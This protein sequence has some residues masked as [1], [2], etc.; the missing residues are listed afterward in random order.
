[1]AAAG[2][3]LKPCI[4]EL[5]GKSASIVFESA[6][7]EQAIDGALMG[8]YSNNG[9]QCLAGSRI[10]VQ[11]TIADA[12]IGRF[13]ERAQAMKIGDPMAAETGDRA[14]RLQGPHGPR[15]QFLSIWPRRTAP[16]C[17]CGGK[18]AEGFEKGYYIEP[19]AVLA[20]SN[21]ARVCQ[22][23]IFGP[24]ATF[25]LFDSLDEAIAIANASSF[26]LVAYVWSQDLHAV[27]RCS[28]DIRAGVIWVNTPMVRELRAPFGGYK[29]SGVG[30]DGAAASAQFFTEV[31][32]TT[33]PVDP[34]TM[35]RLGLRPARAAV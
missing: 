7:I 18:R 27:M 25:V 9:Q 4:L 16:K 28:R 32:T 3:N 20:A 30:R 22:Q 8:I 33:I 6:D 21:D 31:K 34:V 14:A 2:A 12:F 23:E 26:G 15:A 35:P 10:L 5:G 24:F 11:R 19:T 17:W 13:V 1:M 29:E